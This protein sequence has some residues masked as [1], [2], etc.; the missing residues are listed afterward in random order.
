[1]SL[2]VDIEKTLGSFRLNVKFEAENE[3][4]AV[5]GSSGC[6]KSMTLKCI[7]GIVTPDKGKIVIDGKTLFD[8]EKKINLP[9]QKRSVGY[10]FQ[11]YALF[12]NMTVEQNVAIGAGEGLRSEGVRKKVKDKID[13]FHLTGL[14]KRYP[15]QLSGGQKQ[16]V[17]L[18]RIMASSPT[19]LMLDEPF[20][21]LDDYLKWQ[22]EQEIMNMLDGYGKTTLLVSHNR[23]E[24]YRLCN[25]IGIIVDGTMHPMA[26][27]KELFDSPKTRAA[28]LLTGCKNIS[29]IE[30]FGD[31]RVK[32]LDWGIELETQQTVEDDINF[33]G[34]HAHTI[35]AIG[36]DEEMPSQE[37]IITCKCDRK[38]ATSWS[39]L[40][41][42]SFDDLQDRNVMLRMEI[43]AR[44]AER[45]MDQDHI[46]I[47]LPEEKLLLLR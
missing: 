15:N 7:A 34:I 31:N 10:L 47:W 26:E 24:V 5:F 11:N 13:A 21:A 36:D 20:S 16:R 1:M 33:V 43:S 14:E 46:K 29:R 18:A 30:K 38:I 42:L 25:K 37:N 23:G 19:A 8:S 12:P 44:K 45:F 27:K 32:A 39:M 17:A 40:F 22:L 28:A 6:G 9:P 3:T 2:F 4:V 41:L 35:R